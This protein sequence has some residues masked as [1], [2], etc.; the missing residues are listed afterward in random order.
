MISVGDTKKEKKFWIWENSTGAC[1]FP[2]TDPFSVLFH[3]IAPPKS[4]TNPHPITE[5]EAA[6]FPPGSSRYGVN[7]FSLKQKW[8]KKK[9][10][11]QN[12][13][14]G[15]GTH[16]TQILNNIREICVETKDNGIGIKGRLTWII[17][18][19]SH[20]SSGDLLFTSHTMWIDY[21]II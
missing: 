5:L 12:P 13:M 18:H 3:H 15:K 10:C 6:S 20:L 2:V 1:V 8:K 21:L 4:R 7:K 17:S 19:V 9:F 11:S 14:M 16:A